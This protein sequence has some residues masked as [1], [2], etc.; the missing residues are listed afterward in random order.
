MSAN[1]SRISFLEREVARLSKQVEIL[2]NHVLYSTD[3]KLYYDENGE[4]YCK[5]TNVVYQEDSVSDL[6][7]YTFLALDEYRIIPK[8][9][10]G[11]N[12]GDDLL[13]NLLNGKILDLN[14][15]QNI[16]KI[17][18]FLYPHWIDAKY[19]LLSP[20]E[21]NKEINFS[22]KDPLPFDSHLAYKDAY[23]FI[24]KIQNSPYYSRNELMSRKIGKIF[25]DGLNLLFH[26]FP[27]LHKIE[28][29][30]SK[31]H[32]EA[33]F[34]RQFKSKYLIIETYLS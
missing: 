31:Q 32:A 27:R 33:I 18:I 20:S 5:G 23:N 9:L 12:L 16:E 28:I 21:L 17:E 34:L 24:H 8:Y 25:H 26:S 13:P 3:I 15:Y 14:Y 11:I 6:N 4:T 19:F 30:I 7:S 10:R 29:H 2:T 1:N 22:F